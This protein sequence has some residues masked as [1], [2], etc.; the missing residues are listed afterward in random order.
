MQERPLRKKT[1][2]EEPEE[3]STQPANPSTETEA[4]LPDLESTK[5]GGLAFVDKTKV[6]QEKS[7]RIQRIPDLA[8]TNTENED[9]GEELKIEEI[10]DVTEEEARKH[11]LQEA[12]RT[13]SKVI[14]DLYIGKEQ[15]YARA[16]TVNKQLERLGLELAEANLESNSDD[17]RALTE[18]IAP[19][20]AESDRFSRYKTAEEEVVAR[21]AEV[22]KYR[23]Q[24]KESKKKSSHINELLVNLEELRAR[25]IEADTWEDPREATNRRRNRAYEEYRTKKTEEEAEKMAAEKRIE[26]EKE[27]ARLTEEQTRQKYTENME[28]TEIIVGK[29]KDWK[30]PKKDPVKRLTGLTRRSTIV[31]DLRNKKLQFG[32]Q[33][34]ASERKL[35]ENLNSIASVFKS[36][37]GGDIAKAARGE[38]TFTEKVVGWWKDSRVGKLF[39]NKKTETYGGVDRDKAELIE[40]YNR[41][42]STY[43]EIAGRPKR[44]SGDV[45]RELSEWHAQR[46]NPPKQAEPSNTSSENVLKGKKA[47]AKEVVRPLA[48]MAIMPI[49]AIAE[50]ILSKRRWEREWTKMQGEHDAELFNEIAEEILT[51]HSEDD[52]AYVAK[53][54]GVPPGKLTKT[55][56]G[57]FFYVTQEG[58]ELREFIMDELRKKTEQKEKS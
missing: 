37:Y 33:F 35:E 2:R 40:R 21:I 5:D 57:E 19:L 18:R 38:E 7:K 10:Q 13:A 48:E 4:A 42:L 24:L 15:R 6:K 39:G 47:V 9:T 25:I 44:T 3:R 52:L 46:D 54:I 36:K 32:A 55:D 45:I 23:D 41:L 30:N 17:V 16:Q 12:R 1:D 8:L 56:V 27:V 28:D 34:E 53:A 49:L 14:P 20:Q 43:G 31:G 58:Q 51:T 29:E 11:L 26:T 50:P 22:K